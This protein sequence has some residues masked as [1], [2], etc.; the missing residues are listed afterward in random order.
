[1]VFDVHNS[2]INFLLKAIFTTVDRSGHVLR[3]RVVQPNNK[4][5]VFNKKKKEKKKRR[6]SFVGYEKFNTIELERDV[7]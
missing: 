1:M 6:N 5:K 3:S 4:R 7:A 2:V